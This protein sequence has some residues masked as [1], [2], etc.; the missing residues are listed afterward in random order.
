M[1]VLSHHQKIRIYKLL[2][3]SDVFGIIQSPSY[4]NPVSRRIFEGGEIPSTTPVSQNVLTSNVIYQFKSGEQTI[5]IWISVIGDNARR[6]PTAFML[7]SPP[8]NWD[9]NL[10]SMPVVVEILGLEIQQFEK[11]GAHI[12]FYGHKIET[13][14]Y[15]D[16]DWS[17]KRSRPSFRTRFLVVKQEDPQF[18]VVL[19]RKMAMEY[20]II[21]PQRSTSLDMRSPRLITGYKKGFKVQK[22]AH[23]SSDED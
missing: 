8:L 16:L 21:V 11:Y 1:L 18:D 4:Q 7:W 10:I 13:K 17:L 20:G 23:V 5:P 22:T 15:V 6:V 12:E 19:G 9:T 14:G 2:V 3:H